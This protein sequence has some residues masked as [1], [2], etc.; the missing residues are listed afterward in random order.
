MDINE[1]IGIDLGAMIREV[2]D[3]IEPPY[4]VTLTY[5]GIHLATVIVEPGES[6]LVQVRGLHVT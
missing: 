4:E 6:I 3:H 5:E 2:D 1:G